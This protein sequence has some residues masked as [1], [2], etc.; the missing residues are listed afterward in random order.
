MTSNVINLN[1][2]IIRTESTEKELSPEE[3]LLLAIVG[4]AVLDVESENKHSE[5]AKRF[6][7]EI[8]R[9]DLVTK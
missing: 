4:R 5:E 3:R 6:L 2:D 9:N 1:G 8:K 7:K